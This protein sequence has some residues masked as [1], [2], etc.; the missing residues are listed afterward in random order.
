MMVRFI[1]LYPMCSTTRVS[2]VLFRIR[3]GW[4]DRFRHVDAQ[5]GMAWFS[6]MQL[7]KMRHACKDGDKLK[8][9]GWQRHDGRWFG[10]QRFVDHDNGIVR[11]CPPSHAL[12]AAYRV[13]IA[14]HM[15]VGAGNGACV[16]R[17]KR[18]H[19]CRRHVRAGVDASE[20]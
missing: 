13:I 9:W 15:V 18:C 2:T 3:V 20:G 1:M 7:E 17:E 5:T 14:V 16:A 8:N 12:F 11:G 6:G 10:Q 4:G 19:D